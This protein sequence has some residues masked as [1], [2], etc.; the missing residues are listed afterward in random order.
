MDQPTQSSSRTSSSVT[1]AELLVRRSDEKLAQFEVQRIAEALMRETKLA[2]EIAVQIS[3][4]VN[5]Q[6]Q[7]LEI[8]ALTSSLIRGL[9]DAKLLEHGLTAAHRLHA[10][11]GVP[12]YDAD[13]I[14]QGS[15]PEL[16]IAN[17]PEGTSFALAEAIKRE[18]SMLAVF[19]ERV[20]IGHLSGD[21]HIENL[22]EIDRL[23]TMTGSI[24]FIKRNGIVLPGGFAGSR[25]ARRPEV[26]ASHLVKYTAAMHGYFSQAIAWDAVNFAFAPLMVELSH[27][28]KKQVAQSLLFELSTPAVARG[29][30]PMRCELHLD[31]DAPAYLSDRP[32]IGAGGEQL[33]KTY[34]EFGEV[35]RDFLNALFEVYLEGDGQDW[36]LNGPR[37][38]LHVTSRFIDNPG[39]RSFLDLASKVAIERGGVT[40]AFDRSSEDDEA[41]TTFTN[42][43]GITANVLQ[44]AKD[45]W[46]W[47][48]AILSSVALNLPR[49]GQRAD[50]DELRVFALLSELLELAAQASLEKRVFLEKLLARGEAGVLSLLAMRPNNEPFLRLNWTSHAICPVGLSELVKIIKGKSLDDSP[51]AQ[52]FAA[53]IIAH[54]SAETERLSAKHKVRFI[55]A[56]SHDLIAPHRLAKLDRHQTETVADEASLKEIYYTN[57]AKLPV[58][59]N[60]GALEK[61]RIEGVM[62]GAAI[63]GAATELWGNDT[64]LK[65]EQMAVLISRAFYQTNNAAFILSPEFTICFACRSATRGIIDHCPQCNSDKIDILAQAVNYYGRVS[66]WPAWKVAELRL[67]KRKPIQ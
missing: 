1:E 11:L 51:A 67:R 35:A 36:S 23:T 33:E 29:G 38:I 13:Q 53:K 48:S 5:A 25:P 3:L 47:R 65:P 44:R 34:G 15:A 37:P 40:F 14:I 19:S 26:L 49:L 46:Q 55:L 39:Y 2:P 6:I 7:R 54:L 8:K 20:A 59:S 50:G 27:E 64:P 52:E 58:T 18:Y 57:S 42:R 31:W 56:E 45:S 63:L 30:Q 22:G 16:K 61:I 43:Y 10:R 32:A 62:Q 66:T 17:G 9:V 12:M 4:E 60:A 21:L 24:D 28:E 41:L